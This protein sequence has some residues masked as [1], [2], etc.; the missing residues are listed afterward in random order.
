MKLEIEAESRIQRQRYQWVLD[1][2]SHFKPPQVILDIGCQKGDL[3]SEFQRLGY[4]PHG[5]EIGAEAVKIAKDRYPTIDFQ[6]ADCEKEIPYEDNYF[7]L[8]W[9]GEVIEH[10]AHTDVFVEELSRVLKPGGRLILTT[11]L[12]NR[13]KCLYITLFRFEKHFDP[14][15]SHYRFYTKRSL[16]EVLRK[17]GLEVCRIEYAGR[18][19]IIARCMCFVAQKRP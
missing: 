19:P 5:I 7:D 12:H 16:T 4:E 14:E 1:E 8:I 2:V 9:A 18:I 6:L 10:I 15:F 13:L 3:C 17:R 11:P